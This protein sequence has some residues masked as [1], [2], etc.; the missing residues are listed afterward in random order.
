MHWTKVNSG[1]IKMYM[2]EV[3]KISQN[4]PL[5]FERQRKSKKKSAI[6]STDYFYISLKC[7]TFEAAVV[8]YLA[9]PTT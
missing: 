1:L 6:L 8:Y 7:Y 9:S 2:E 3:R 4:F 5:F